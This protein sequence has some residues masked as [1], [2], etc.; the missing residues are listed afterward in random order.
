MLHE[1]RAAIFACIHSESHK[2][3]AY[4]MLILLTGLSFA[5]LAA[6][7]KITIYECP[8]P[9]GERVFVDRDSCP[10]VQIRTLVF[11][12]SITP[13]PAK[14][15]KPA[16]PEKSRVRGN[17]RS[18]SARRP[19]QPLAES[20]LCESGGQTWYQHSSCSNGGA[21]GGKGQSTRQTRIARTQACHEISRAGSLLRKGNRHDERASPYEKA[22]GKDPCA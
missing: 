15:A 11:E 5:P 14:A 16:K 21:G 1:R 22:L 4:L 19:A 8:G 3:P 10:E 13:S 12:A 18:N 17:S 6:A 2:M 9:K 20:Y 7:S